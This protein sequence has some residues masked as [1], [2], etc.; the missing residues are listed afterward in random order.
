[1]KILICGVGAIGE[2]HLGNLLALGYTDI[3]LMR[4]TNNTLRTV[5]G[6]FN[7][8]SD[9]ATALADKPDVVFVCNPTSLHVDTIVQALDAGSH[10]FTEKPVATTLEEC[11]AIQAAITRS[12]KSVMVGYNMRFHPALMKVKSWIDS[13]R[14]GNGIYARTQRGEYLPGWH[15]WEDY[16]EGYAARSDLVGGPTFTLSHEIDLLLWIL[17]KHTDVKAPAN[18]ASSLELQTEHGI[19]IDILLGFECGITG[20]IHLDY[21]HRPPARSS[22]FVGK[23]GRIEFEYYS[24]GQSC[25]ERKA[26]SR[27]RFTKRQP[28][29]TATICSSTKSSRSSRRSRQAKGR[30]QVLTTVQPWSIWRLRRLLMPGFKRPPERN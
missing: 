12:G 23:G 9:L 2:R 7:T 22:E 18:T 13:G 14:I 1:M 10:V 19:D 5:E 20:S 29:S 30:H 17:G 11:E 15:P 8:Y 24:G 25:T 21:F 3:S 4:T 6:V 26:L 27:S 16:R 28:T